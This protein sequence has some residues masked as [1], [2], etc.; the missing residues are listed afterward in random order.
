MAD[1]DNFAALIGYGMRSACAENESEAAA[2]KARAKEIAK[3]LLEWADPADLAVAV[4]VS[5][6]RRWAAAERRLGNDPVAKVAA[7]EED[8]FLGTRDDE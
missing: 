7:I 3:K 5:T 4:A 1:I 2:H 8:L 6:T